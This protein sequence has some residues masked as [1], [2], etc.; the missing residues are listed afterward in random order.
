MGTVYVIGAGLA[1]LAA[2]V[3]LASQGQPVVLVDGAKQAGGRCRS[4]HD[5]QLDCRIDNGNHLMLS[6]NWAVKAYADLI[7]GRAGLY[8]ADTAQLDFLDL[9]D[10][11]RWSLR[12]S[13]G[14]LPMW[15][16][17]PKRRVAGATLRDHLA[18]GGLVFA[19]PQDRV[20][21][22]APA[23]GPIYDRFVLPLTEAVMN[24]GPGEASA[25]LLRRVMLETFAKGGRACRPVIAKEGLSDA[26]VDPALAYL[27]TKQA[28]LQLGRR[29]AGLESADGRVTALAF[30]RGAD[31]LG[32]D[33]RVIL[34]LPPE[35]TAPLIGL[36]MPLD[37]VP[38]V[39]AHYR[40]DPAYA[41]DRPTLLGLIGGTAHWVFRRGSLAS[42]TISNA[43]FIVQAAPETIA[44][45]CWADVARALGMD[46]GTV[47]P[48]RIV[49]EK[50][51]TFRQT[52]DALAKRPGVRTRFQNLFLAGDW[53]DTGLPATIEGALRS[54]FAAAEAAQEAQAA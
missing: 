53:T 2:A 8:E 31:R 34:A 37:A 51:A 15:L 11:A 52:P 13:D 16:F 43:G 12:L 5:D 54:G 36:D 50:R 18:L 21:D 17:D 35:K 1:G 32:A 23:A 24:A 33:D 30:A 22:R 19:K 4:F 29:L 3:K 10:G 39:N 40:L 7:G 25:Y 48:W 46:A 27:R 38:I 6:G 9:R 14:P 42:V 26:L 28:G 44:E 20:A 47:P 49:K 45:R 41:V